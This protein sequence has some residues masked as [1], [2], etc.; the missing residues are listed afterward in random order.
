M[1]VSISFFQCTPLPNRQ[2][3]G[4]ANGHSMS[5]KVIHCCVIDAAYMTN[6]RTDRRTNIM[7]IVRRFVLWM[8]RALKRNTK[9][10]SG[11]GPWERPPPTSTPLATSRTRKLVYSIIHTVRFH[12]CVESYIIGGRIE[13]S[14]FHASDQVP[15]VISDRSGVGSAVIVP[16][17]CVIPYTP[18]ALLIGA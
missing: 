11:W 10:F 5:L 14:L 1:D 13:T 2:Y 7:P 4:T 17:G 9:N 8:H 18:T 6:R 16:A 15:G 12:A 3:R